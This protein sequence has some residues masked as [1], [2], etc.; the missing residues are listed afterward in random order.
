MIALYSILLLLYLLQIKSYSKGWSSL[1]SVAPTKELEL[2]VLVAFRNEEKHLPLLLSDLENQNYPLS[3]VQ[4]IFIDDSSED[5]SFEI[6]N[7]SS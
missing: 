1:P 3:K 5:K 6:I 7:T 4:F 2:S